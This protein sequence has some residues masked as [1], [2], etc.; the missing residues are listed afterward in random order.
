MN[1]FCN[2]C[3]LSN[4]CKVTHSY[5]HQSQLTIVDAD[6]GEQS[7]KRSMYSS[8]SDLAE[9]DK[10]C[11][12]CFHDGSV[13]TLYLFTEN[14]CGGDGT[15]SMSALSN[16]ALMRLQQIQYDRVFAMS[17]APPFSLVPQ[18][19]QR[20]PSQPTDSLIWSLRSQGLPEYRQ[21]YAWCAFICVCMFLA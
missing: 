3:M 8:I 6:R 1:R 18:H 15:C 4:T 5:S 20:P 12:S 21:W 10:L 13:S 19:T 11:R 14:V 2:Q 7:L 9:E 17:R 16:R